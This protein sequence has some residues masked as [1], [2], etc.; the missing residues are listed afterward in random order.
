MYLSSDLLASIE[1]YGTVTAITLREF[2][3]SVPIAHF[4]SSKPTAL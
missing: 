3:A 4:T 2:V 1:K